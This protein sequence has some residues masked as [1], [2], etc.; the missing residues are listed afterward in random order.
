MTQN[1]YNI[2]VATLKTHYKRGNRRAV[3]DIAQSLA[4]AFA[5]DN[6]DFILSTFIYAATHPWQEGDA[7]PP[8]ALSF[9][10]LDI[11]YKYDNDWLNL[12]YTTPS[13]P[14]IKTD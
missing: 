12:T 1:D 5:K 2:I 14:D 10:T 11:D 8:V 13:E 6:P 9:V 7:W 4:R 3:K